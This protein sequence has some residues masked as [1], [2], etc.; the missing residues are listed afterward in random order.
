MNRKEAKKETFKTNTFELTTVSNAPVTLS[1]LPQEGDFV[2]T[3][4]GKSI[5]LVENLKAGG[6]GIIYKVDIDCNLVAKIYL[7]GKFTK[8][9][10]AKI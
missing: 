1:Y 9:K 8:R 2:H 6:E 10:E 3:I 7:K 5:K 4:D